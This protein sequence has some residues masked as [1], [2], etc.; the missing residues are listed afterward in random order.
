MR[1]LFSLSRVSRTRFCT[2]LRADLRVFRA[3]RRVGSR[4]SRV[5]V[6]FVSHSVTCHHTSFVWVARCS[7][8]LFARVALAVSVFVRVSGP[9]VTRVL[10][11]AWS[12]VV[13]ACH[14]CCFT[15]VSRRLRVVINCFSLIKTR[16]NNV[17]SLGHI[18]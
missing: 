10:L 2:W 15:Y 5:V 8:A 13:R 14:T 3:R 7:R 9:C 17:N 6:S 11:R 12:C 1:R 18:F 16:V 4:V